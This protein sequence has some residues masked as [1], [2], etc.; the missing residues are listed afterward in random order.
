[1]IQIHGSLDQPGHGNI[2]KHQMLINNGNGKKSTA[3]A[4]DGGNETDDM[5]NIPAE[6]CRE[7]K[8]IYRINTTMR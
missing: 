2:V 6:E 5:E 4:V 8:V 7:N 3:A 1:M